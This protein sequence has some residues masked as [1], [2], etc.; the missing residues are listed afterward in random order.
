MTDGFLPMN[1]S[2]DSSS[3]TSSSS[4]LLSSSCS[5]SKSASAFITTSATTSSASLLRP[6]VSDQSASCSRFLHE[7]DHHQPP[8]SV[9]SSKTRKKEKIRTFVFSTIQKRSSGSVQDGNTES[10][11][12]E[13]SIKIPE[14]CE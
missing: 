11:I 8:Q 10:L 2:D 14:V 13:L 12:D 1:D 3:S 6:T 7:S 5:I 4:S 9:L